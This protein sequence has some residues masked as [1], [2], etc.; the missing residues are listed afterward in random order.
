MNLRVHRGEII[1]LAKIKSKKRLRSFQ[2]LNIEYSDYAPKKASIAEPRLEGGE[3]L[4]EIEVQNNIP[5]S[6]YE[7]MLDNLKGD[8]AASVSVEAS[9]SDMNFGSGISLRVRITLTCNQSYQD[10]ETAYQFAQQIAQDQLD[11]NIPEVR[12]LY[13][14]HLQSEK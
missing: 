8:G 4:H 9:F 3:E 12:K 7:H 11:S 10:I 14:E 6:E 2:D 5:L 1:L 13:N